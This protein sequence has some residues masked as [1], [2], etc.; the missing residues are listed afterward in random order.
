MFFFILFFSYF[1]RPASFILRAKLADA[2]S[3]SL[4]PQQQ[5]QLTANTGEAALF[6]PTAVPTPVKRGPGRP[7]IK[8]GGPVNQGARGTPRTRKPI[9]PLVVPLGS[10]PAA[11][12]INRSPAMSPAPSPAHSEKAA[13]TTSS[14]GTGGGASYYQPSYEVGD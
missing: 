12:P 10:S 9:G 6:T 2:T 3:A 8:T 1:T 4:D 11:T 5:Q 14:S 7:R 13:S